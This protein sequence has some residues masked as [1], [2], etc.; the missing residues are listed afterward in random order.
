MKRKVLKF[1]SDEK[2]LLKNVEY[3]LWDKLNDP[4]ITI[5]YE[6]R[7]QIYGAWRGLYETLNFKNLFESEEKI[8]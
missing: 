2:K 8:L 7:E 3:L 1:T 5:D 4:E 6:E